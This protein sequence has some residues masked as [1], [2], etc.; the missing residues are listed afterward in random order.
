MGEL[1]CIIHPIHRFKLSDWLK[2]GHMT[3]IIFDNVHAW[4]LIISLTLK[5]A[6]TAA[7]FGTQ[8]PTFQIF[9]FSIKT[10]NS[11]YGVCKTNIDCSFIWEM[12]ENCFFPW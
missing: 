2:E 3:W 6:I 5:E 10:Q 11:I 4:K 8:Q 1:C 12:V 7:K 9:Q